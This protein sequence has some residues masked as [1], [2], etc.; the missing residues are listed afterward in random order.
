MAAR[1][2]L[3]LFHF[4][5]SPVRCILKTATPVA[6]LKTKQKKKKKN[7]TCISIDLGNPTRWCTSKRKAFITA[8]WNMLTMGLL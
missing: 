4:M 3:L 1:Q 6:L 7:G 8:E 5:C 2:L